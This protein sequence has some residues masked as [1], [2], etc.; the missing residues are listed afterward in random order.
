MELALPAG[1]PTRAWVQD[2]LSAALLPETPWTLIG[3]QAVVATWRQAGLPEP[4]G[5]LWL[6]V[7]E[8]GKRLAALVPWLETWAELPLRRDATVVAVGGGVLTDMAGLAASLYMRG[9]AWHA[10]PTT[11]LAQVDAGLGGKTAVDLAA[12]KNLAGAFHPPTRMV[13]C[14]A[15][16]A[17]LPPRQL[18][19]GRW[20][21]VKMAL[22]EGDLAG[23]EALLDPPMPAAEALA[24]AL[25]AKAGIVQRDPREA[26]ERRLLNLGHTLGHALEAGSDYRLLHGEAVG[27]GL[28][29]ACYLAED[30]GLGPFPPAFLDR[31]A[32]ELRPLAP[33]AAPWETCLSLLARDKKSGPDPEAEGGSAIHCILP[34]PGARAEQRFLPAAAWAH[35]HRRLTENLH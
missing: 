25:Q 13:V 32:R 34:C 30:Q 19:S 6:P 12:G 10:W 15:F 17:T 23:A 9:I 8:Q 4:P 31:L 1:F 18:A 14:R 22:L 27:L 11:L 28:L 20:E 29:A 3:D 7:T 21:L 2:E 35:A 16:L 5:T 26:G 33:L 24:R